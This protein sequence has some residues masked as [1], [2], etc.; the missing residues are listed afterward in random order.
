MSI[1]E[2]VRSYI[3]Q[4]EAFAEAVLFEYIKTEENLKNFLK[5]AGIDRRYK[6]DI[7]SVH[8]QVRSE[9]GEARH[10]LILKSKSRTYHIELKGNAPF[11]GRQKEAISKG[12]DDTPESKRI[13]ILIAPSKLISTIEISPTIKCITW[14]QIDNEL[15]KGRNPLGNLSD[16][17]QFESCVK[18][19]D[20]CNDARIFSGYARKQIPSGSWGSLWRSVTYIKSRLADEMDFGRIGGP[21]SP[22]NCFY[23]G[24]WCNRNDEPWW[25]GW[26][27][28]GGSRGRL[29]AAL[30]LEKIKPDDTTNLAA[31]PDWYDG[32]A[33]GEVLSNYSDNNKVDYVDLNE[34]SVALKTTVVSCV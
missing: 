6:F 20:V 4:P 30:I 22:R 2:S 12:I 31:L 23:Y 15:F 34:V 3:N 32:N 18:W 13:D 8:R 21:R 7:T 17:W 28:T 26:I 19:S 14:E 33:L 10:D 27:F 5:M 24:V 11:T 9:A 29:K 25:L 1:I 16:L